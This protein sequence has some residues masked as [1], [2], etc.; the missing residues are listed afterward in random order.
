MT[1]HLHLQCRYNP[2]FSS[3]LAIGETSGK[4]CPVRVGS[5]QQE[6]RAYGTN[7]DVLDP[8][9]PR[10]ETGVVT[11]TEETPGVPSRPAPVK[12]DPQVTP[13]SGVLATVQSPKVSKVLFTS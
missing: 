11:F 6:G 4:I 13:P 10:R 2:T 12:V 1:C 5:V 3:S 8:G 9:E 7:D